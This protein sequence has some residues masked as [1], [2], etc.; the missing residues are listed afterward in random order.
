M[1]K[2]AFAKVGWREGF[3]V[4]HMGPIVARSQGEDGNSLPSLQD[5]PCYLLLRPADPAV[6][7]G[8]P[9]LPAVPASLILAPPASDLLPPSLQPSF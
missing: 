5:C 6:L 1:R 9:F 8:V 4:I 3:Y 7:T 2:S